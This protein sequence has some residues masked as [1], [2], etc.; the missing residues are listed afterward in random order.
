M[1]L[2]AQGGR[3]PCPPPVRP[4]LDPL[5]MYI[6]S[7]PLSMEYTS[8]FHLSSTFTLK[9]LS[10]AL[11]SLGTRKKAEAGRPHIRWVSMDPTNLYFF[12]L[13]DGF[14]IVP[15]GGRQR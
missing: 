4:C 2:G 8:H 7:G 9:T 6:N 10:V 1:H 14:L 12:A 11:F 15:L 3:P 13:D 5:G